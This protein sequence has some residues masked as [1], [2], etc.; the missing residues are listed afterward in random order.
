MQSTARLGLAV[1]HEQSGELLGSFQ[2]GLQ[3][4]ISIGNILA[5]S[6]VLD[7]GQYFDNQILKKILFSTTLLSFF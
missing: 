5:I 4:L 7:F 2:Q 1:V 6:T 3:F